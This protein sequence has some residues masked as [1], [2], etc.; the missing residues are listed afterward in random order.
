MI[1]YIYKYT[2]PTN[3][4][5]Y[6][7]QTINLHRRLIKHRCDT[8]KCHT[9]FGKAVK[10]YGI[11]HFKFEILFRIVSSNKRRL[12]IML[13]VLEISMITKYNSYHSG[14]NSTLGGSSGSRINN[15]PSSEIRE[16]IRNSLK[17]YYEIH[18]DLKVEKKRQLNYIRPKGRKLSLIHKEKISRALIG[19]K[20]SEET[21]L[22]ISQN[23]KGK[24]NNSLEFLKKIRD[25]AS[26]IRSK[27]V[28]QYSVEGLLLGE[29]KSAV[30]AAK[31][32][33]LNPRLIGK[34]CRGVIKTSGG[35][36]WKFKTI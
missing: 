8:P 35:F 28:I 10:K 15:S 21:K 18:N 22:K 16:K 3:N 23:N 7:G 13:N 31:T 29:F 12:S 26:Q 6:I 4:K 1:G 25:K 14:Y 30:E 5:V 34:C 17:N 11:N 33:N 27:S 19:R 24:N 20:L 2:N 9:K 32:L 36:I